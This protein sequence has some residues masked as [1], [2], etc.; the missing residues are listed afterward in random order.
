MT[1]RSDELLW[2]LDELNDVEAS[3]DNCCADVDDAM[4]GLAYKQLRRTIRTLEQKWLDALSAERMADTEPSIKA[5]EPCT[6]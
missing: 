3:L 4:L 6:K 1:L 5:G 2:L